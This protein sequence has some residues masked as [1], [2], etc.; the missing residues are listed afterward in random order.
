MAAGVGACSA[1][2]I[3]SA[4]VV[5]ELSQCVGAGG[6]TVFL[7]V[8]NYRHCWRFRQSEARLLAGLFYCFF[9][10]GFAVLAWWSRKPM[11]IRMSAML[12][13]DRI[14]LAASVSISF[15]VAASS[16]RLMARFV[17]VMLM[18]DCVPGEFGAA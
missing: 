2:L 11:R 4:E 10:F 18:S 9:G 5:P 12:D 8:S 1:A 17:L 7:P 15:M 6:G 3:D 14:S 16:R 13:T